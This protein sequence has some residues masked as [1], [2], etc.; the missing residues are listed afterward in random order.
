M[1][2]LVA[3]MLGPVLAA[4]NDPCTWW[5]YFGIRF[6]RKVHLGVFWFGLLAIG[7]IAQTIPSQAQVDRMQKQVDQN[8]SRSQ[9]NT[10]AIGIHD[11]RSGHEGMLLRMANME[12][13]MIHTTNAVA[14]I[15]GEATGIKYSVILGATGMTIVQAVIAIFAF[16]RRHNGG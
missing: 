16:R 5:T 10:V 14:L 13:V 7:S 8:E 3:S 15:Q 11:A 2:N 1:L 9:A 12:D 6:I 4:I